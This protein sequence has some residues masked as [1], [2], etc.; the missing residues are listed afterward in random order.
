[1]QQAIITLGGGCFWCTEAVFQRIRG[2]LRVESGYCNGRLATRPS[3]EDVCRG[4]TGFNEVVQL[5]YDPQVDL[6]PLEPVVKHFT[7]VAKQDGLPIG[8]PAEY[9]EGMYQHQ[10]P[11]GMMTNLTRQ[12][13]E[14]KMEHRLDEILEEVVQVRRE[15]GYPVMATPYSQIVGAQAFD[16]LI[17]GAR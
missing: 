7:A 5:G 4:D 10:V 2:V 14:I 3:Y 8:K 13:R 6:K 9:D 11:G 1:M 17:A 12:L 16:N 15:Y